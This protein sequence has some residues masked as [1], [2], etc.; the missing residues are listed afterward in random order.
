MKKLKG[1][2]FACNKVKNHYF[3]VW[4]SDKSLLIRN[5]K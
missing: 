5:V 3:F 4:K 1:Y 2:T